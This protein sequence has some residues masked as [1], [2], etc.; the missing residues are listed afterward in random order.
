MIMK[1]RSSYYY[2]ITIFNVLTFLSSKTLSFATSSS[3]SSS[4]GL[5]FK[6]ESISKLIIQEEAEEEIFD[7]STDQ[8]KLKSLTATTSE[9]TSTTTKAS[10]SSLI[11]SSSFI[12]WL[13]DGTSS[14]PHILG[15]TN[16]VKVSKD[17]Y[18]CIQPSI[19]WFGVD[20]IPIFESQILREAPKHHPT[21]ATISSTSSTYQIKV[22]IKDSRTDFGNTS[23]ESKTSKLMKS[24]VEKCK[25]EGVNIVTCKSM[26]STRSSS[27]SSSSSSSP[28]KWEITSELRLQM[29]LQLPNSRFFILPPGF[30]SIGS[31]IVKKT[32][33]KRS[34]ETL[35]ELKKEYKNWATRQ[36]QRQRSRSKQ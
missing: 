3:S 28:R 23:R 18:D 9:S 29:V 4:K 10:E 19:S 26:D 14:N 7:Q 12:D 15:T 25:F 11:F 16:L 33:E 2:I 20:L 24:L 32:C 13:E 34:K 21:S 5:L 1:I 17:T 30:K 36:R 22:K 35:E 27:T 31:R 8:F 6:G